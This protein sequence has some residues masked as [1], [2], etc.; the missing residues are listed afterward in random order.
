MKKEQKNLVVVAAGDNSLHKDWLKGSPN[1]DLMIIYFGDEKDKYKK[2]CK[3]Y[4]QKK[5]LFKLQN[6]KFGLDKFKVDYDYVWI[7]ND[8]LVLHKPAEQLK[9][10]FEIKKR[11]NQK[12]PKI[13]FYYPVDCE[14]P[15][16]GLD[17]FD[18][19]DVPVAYTDFGVKQTLERIPQFKDKIKRIPHGVDQNVFKPISKESIKHVRREFFKLDSSRYFIINVKYLIKSATLEISCYMKAGAPP[20]SLPT[21][22]P[23]KRSDFI[24]TG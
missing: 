13:I 17:I 11:N 3:Y 1:F 15:R 22:D 14:M 6:I 16:N 4:I 20:F 23:E 24:K 21:P 8:I 2:D 12:I 5:G 9:K 18:L 19:T 10:L 7:L